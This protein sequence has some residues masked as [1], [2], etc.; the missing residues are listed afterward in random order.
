MAKVITLSRNFLDNHPRKGQPTYFVEKFYMWFWNNVETKYSDGFLPDMIYDLNKEKFS[1]KEIDLFV[2][3]C[4]PDIKTEKGH[5]IR[6]GNRFKAG[7]FF[8]PRTWYAKP[9]NSKQIILAP[10]I[11][12]P[13]TWDFHVDVNGVMSMA[14]PGQ[15]LKYVDEFDD[16][17]A[18]NDGLEP[19]DFI[20][21]IAMPYYKK[22]KDS[23][24]M[25]II[26]WNEKINY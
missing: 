23:G 6:A 8:S 24:P 10:D 16:I 3:S 20:N 25:Q 11:K 21:W 4:N 1:I 5:T 15:Q 17:I 13:K 2:D 12:I 9:Y 18:K 14:E 19:N 26:C 7:E 22:E